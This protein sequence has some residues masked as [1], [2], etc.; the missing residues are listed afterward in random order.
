MNTMKK[1]TLGIALA[2]LCLLGG[3]C[4]S[5]RQRAYYDA[6]PENGKP[7]LVQKASKDYTIENTKTFAAYKDAYTISR[8]EGK[9]LV[10]DKGVYQLYLTKDTTY[11]TVAYFCPQNPWFFFFNTG[12]SIIDR[13]TGDRYMLRE[14][15]HYPMDTCFWVKGVSRKYVRFVLKFPP[16]P[17]NVEK[18][19]L[20]SPSSPSRHNFDGSAWRASR[21]SVRELRP[22]ERIPQGKIIY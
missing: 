20:F 17:L 19:D 9:F 6:R 1:Q 8:L 13:E 18:I 10:E 16:L 12:F 21:L 5:S 7:T 3:S 4:A 22:K 2:A 14:V 15:E 11:L